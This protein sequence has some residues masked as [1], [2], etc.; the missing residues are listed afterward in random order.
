MNQGF[1]SRQNAQNSTD[2]V[3]TYHM[4]TQIIKVTKD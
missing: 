1:S 4:A 3:T 2:M